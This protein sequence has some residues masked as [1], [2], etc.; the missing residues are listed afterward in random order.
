MARVKK[1]ETLSA[2]WEERQKLS[3]EIEK[4]KKKIADAEAK[5]KKL[6]EKIRSE[7]V[8]RITKS[9]FTLEDIIK[10]VEYLCENNLTV[11]DVISLLG[12]SSTA[13]PKESPPITEAEPENKNEDF[14]KMMASLPSY[15]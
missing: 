5:Q 4:T 3:N 6:E 12:D 9:G 1:E 11:N 14:D 7:Q 13:A 10:L 2:L 8:N 15:D